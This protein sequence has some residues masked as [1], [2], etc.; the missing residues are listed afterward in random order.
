MHLLELVFL[1]L[2]YLGPAL[3]LLGL[4][5]EYRVQYISQKKDFAKHKRASWRRLIVLVLAG[6]CGIA[7]SVLQD[8]ADNRRDTDARKYREQQEEREKEFE[9]RIQS[10]DLTQQAVAK[11]YQNILVSIATNRFWDSSVLTTLASTREQSRQIG[12]NIVDL[13]SWVANL[14]STTDA[15]FLQH[16]AQRLSTIEQEL[17]F[18]APY[19]SQWTYSMDQFLQLLSAVSAQHGMRIESDYKGLP[20]LQELCFGSSEQADWG[21]T[22][23]PVATISLASSNNWKCTARIVRLR[24]MLQGAGFNLPRLIIEC[25][26]TDGYS[27]LDVRGPATV[28]A[29]AGQ[30]RQQPLS[31]HD[32][33]AQIDQLVRDFI[34]SQASVF[35]LSSN[36]QS[37]VGDAPK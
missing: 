1:A 14:R 10:I 7:A 24:R 22:T 2:K 19:Y 23:F 28:I 26:S 30:S 15:L 32:Y 29:V 13:K 6:L 4:V 12:T 35:Q 9:Q 25:Q 34:A 11:T 20:S 5:Y 31:D 36:A 21:E 3:L 27:L 37:S 17:S 33:H 18:I 16:E 8:V